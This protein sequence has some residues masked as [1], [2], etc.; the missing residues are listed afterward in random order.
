[1]STDAIEA[2]SFFFGVAITASAAAYAWGKWLRHRYDELKVERG[3]TADAERLRGSST[4]SR[5]SHWKSS[6]LARR[7]VT[8]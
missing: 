8:R 5:H 6:A 7:S 1:M 3:A 2:L 4:P